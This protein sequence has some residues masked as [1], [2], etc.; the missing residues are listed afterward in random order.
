MKTIYA[1]GKYKVSFNTSIR[2]YEV[3][4]SDCETLD[5]AG[6]SIVELAK[7]VIDDSPEYLMVFKEV[8]DGAVVGLFFATDSLDYPTA[9]MYK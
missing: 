5:Y 1:E 8:D 4:D 6:D 2:E 9:I 3:G 7:E